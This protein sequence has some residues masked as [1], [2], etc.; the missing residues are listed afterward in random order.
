VNAANSEREELSQFLL[1]DGMSEG[2]S[3]IFKKD[4]M[5]NWFVL[6]VFEFSCPVQ[7]SGI[8]EFKIAMRKHPQRQIFWKIS[9]YGTADFAVRPKDPGIIEGGMPL[10]FSTDDPRLADPE[11]QYVPGGD[12]EVYNPR[13][14]YQL[15]ELDQ[16]WIIAERFEIEPL[17][18]INSD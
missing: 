3:R 18:Q 7:M 6:S 12:G 14:H 10:R 1:K 9:A 4:G 11:L 8:I 13:R 5:S 17:P 16:S 2:L 15:L